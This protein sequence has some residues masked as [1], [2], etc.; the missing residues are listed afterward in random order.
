MHVPHVALHLAI[1][2]ILL[3]HNMSLIHVLYVLLQEIF[4]VVE[5]TYYN[6]HSMQ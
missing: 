2:H 1:S 4:Y 5:K 6:L 3:P